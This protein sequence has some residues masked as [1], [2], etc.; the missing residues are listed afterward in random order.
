MQAALCT[1]KVGCIR[2]MDNKDKEKHSPSDQSQWSAVE[3]L[4]LWICPFSTSSKINLCGSVPDHPLPALGASSS[5][6]LARLLVSGE[7]L[8][9]I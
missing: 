7:W 4:W 5:R 8:L 6:A 9:F 1:E 3:F 2:G